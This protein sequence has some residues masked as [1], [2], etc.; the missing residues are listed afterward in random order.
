MIKLKDILIERFD[1]S[2]MFDN[3][4]VKKIADEIKKMVK[5]KDDYGSNFDYSEFR[6][7]S[8]EGGFGFKWEHARNWGGQLGVSFNKSGNHTYYNYSYYDKK[9]TGNATVDS[10][11]PFKFKG[12]P[13]VWKDFTNDHLLEFWKKMKSSIKKNE[14]G[15]KAAFEKEVKGQSDH[16]GSKADT[17]RIGYGLSS[18][19]RR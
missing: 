6:F 2:K 8:G 3:S 12:K 11:K 9:R 14:V 13:V 5:F 1:D 19:P 10:S 4:T 15:A 16:Y 17:G 18:Q 7:G